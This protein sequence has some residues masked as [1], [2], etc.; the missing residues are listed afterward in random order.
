MK[1]IVDDAKIETFLGSLWHPK[2]S[3]GQ[4]VFA[5]YFIRAH[6]EAIDQFISNK[7]ALSGA[8]YSTVLWAKKTKRLLKKFQKGPRGY[9]YN[10]GMGTLETL[11]PEARSF[12][13]SGG[14]HESLTLSSRRPA[15]VIT[16]YVMACLAIL[17][18]LWMG[19]T[20]KKALE[21]AGEY[22]IGPYQSVLA[23]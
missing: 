18:L 13:L 19:Y 6:G 11:Y 9:A 22:W 17:V 5:A 20:V 7:I 10:P 3:L 2:T 1:E 16:G 4:R 15:V 14:H 21:E 23:E 8:N 12:R